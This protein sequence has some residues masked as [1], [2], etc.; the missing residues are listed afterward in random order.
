MKVIDPLGEVSLLWLRERSASL[1]TCPAKHRSDSLHNMWCQ[2]TPEYAKLTVELGNPDVWIGQISTSRW[3]LR[4]DDW[5]H[6]KQ[7][8]TQLHEPM[9]AF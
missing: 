8:I 9:E 7:Y 5:D 3:N 4:W 2:I 6:D 1:C